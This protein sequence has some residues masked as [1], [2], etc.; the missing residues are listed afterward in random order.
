M[1]GNDAHSGSRSACASG[2]D[3]QWS[4][5]WLELKPG[6]A[7]RVG[8]WAKGAAGESALMEVVEPSGTHGVRIT[9]N[10]TTWRYGES[11]FIAASDRAWVRVVSPPLGMLLVGPHPVAYY[12]DVS[13]REEP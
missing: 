4:T 2:W 11:T 3:F 5:G 12:D 9:L 1:R 13:L 6:R 8:G 7:Y 10:G